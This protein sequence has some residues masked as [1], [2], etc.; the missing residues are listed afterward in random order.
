MSGYKNY[1]TRDK[2][3]KKFPDETAEE[4][5]Q[6]LKMVQRSKAAANVALGLTTTGKERKRKPGGGARWVGDSASY[7]KKPV[8]SELFGW[9]AELA[10]LEPL[11]KAEEE[12]KEREKEREREEK[13]REREE[14]ERDKKAKE[15]RARTALEKK[16]DAV[17]R[18]KNFN[19]WKE[20]TVLHYIIANPPYGGYKGD[21]YDVVHG[22]P[23]ESG[24]RAQRIPEIF[25][26]A[27]ANKMTR[28]EYGKRHV[29]K[30]RMDPEFI[31][32]KYVKKTGKPVAKSH[33]GS[34]R[35][36]TAPSGRTNR[37]MQGQPKELT[38][39][40]G[41]RP[42]KPGMEGFSGE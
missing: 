11:I 2:P 38:L 34:Q 30:R 10:K 31:S 16:L 22:D 14:K 29:A 40:A 42:R 23:P 28:D 32:K 25:T 13:E 37:L 1:R 8:A 6:R 18:K 15:K 19:P 3:K 12:E 27:K 39:R 24:G 4:K 33:T 20:G 17:L 26:R 35:R 21:E 5:K 9:D 41:A 7:K 36:L